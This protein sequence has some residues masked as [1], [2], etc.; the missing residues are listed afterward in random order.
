[1]DKDENSID[2]QRLRLRRLLRE[3]WQAVDAEESN[4]FKDGL[5]NKLPAFP[6]NV[7]Y[8]RKYNNGRDLLLR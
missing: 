8:M 1:M 3:W 5:D 6:N 2:L 7:E 4:G